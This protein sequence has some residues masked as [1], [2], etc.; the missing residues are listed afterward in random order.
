MWLIHRRKRRRRPVII[1]QRF[2]DAPWTPWRGTC[3]ALRGRLSIVQSGPARFFVRGVKLACRSTSGLDVKSWIILTDDDVGEV[4]VGWEESGLEQCIAEAKT[5]RE[6]VLSTGQCNREVERKGSTTPPDWKRQRLTSV[7]PVASISR[8]GPA[9]QC[10]SNADA[11]ST[12]RPRRLSPQR[13]CFTSH[14]RAQL[15]QAD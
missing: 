9:E 13:Q 5:M 11:R 12:K 1:T 10:R 15:G 2:L 3:S 4:I 7:L 8:G 14:H 6:R